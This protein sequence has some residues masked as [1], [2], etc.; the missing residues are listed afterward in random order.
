[1]KAQSE[2]LASEYDRVVVERN[3]LERKLRIAGGGDGD[4]KKDD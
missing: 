4:N 3:M 1:M 2:N